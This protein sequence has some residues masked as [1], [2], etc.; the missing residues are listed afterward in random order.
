MARQESRYL[1]KYI[2]KRVRV[3]LENP[4]RREY[5]VLESLRPNGC[6]V[7]MEGGGYK[8]V[9]GWRVGGAV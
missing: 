8:M 6:R 5:G 4:D 2:G 9:A 3:D 7:L 1:T